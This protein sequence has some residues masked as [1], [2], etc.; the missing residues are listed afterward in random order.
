MHMIEGRYQRGSGGKEKQKQRKAEKQ[1]Q[2]HI[3]FKHNT[4]Y[5]GMIFTELKFK[6][7]Y[8]NQGGLKYQRAAVLNFN[9]WDISP[10]CCQI[11]YIMWKTIH[12]P[13]K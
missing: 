5:M 1:T 11:S 12:N 13:S 7:F 6:V 3:A 4:T 8:A 2:T 9:R 10:Q